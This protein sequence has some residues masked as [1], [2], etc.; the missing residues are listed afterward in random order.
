MHELAVCQALLEQV[1]EV[2]RQ[3]NALEV[4]SITVRIGPLSGVEPDLLRRAF[5]VA[6]AGSVAAGARLVLETEP[7]RVRCPDCG[8]ERVVPPNRLR[9]PDCGAGP[10]SI[11]SGD[12][13]TL[14]SLALE[15]PETAVPRVGG[16]QGARHV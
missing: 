4:S 6:R 2:A 5:E 15:R 14:A 10:A 13:L 11:I 1:A 3:R 8:A 12:A 16:H 7:V 9:C